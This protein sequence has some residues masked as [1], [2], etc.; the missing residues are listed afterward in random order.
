MFPPAP[1]ALV[2]KKTG[3][4]QKPKSG[5]LG[6]HDSLT[7]APENMKGQ[8]V[9]QEA[10]DFVTG[11]ASIALASSA[12][13]HPQG[14][15]QTQTAKDIPGES[16]I[17]D[18]TAIATG[19]GA[20][21]DASTSTTTGV[22]GDKTKAAV[23]NSMWEK[24]RPIM[25]IIGQICDN[26]ERFGNALSPT[27]PFNSSLYRIRLATLIIPLLLAS[28]F[29][30]PYS[31]IKVLTFSVGFGFFGDPVITPAVSRLNKIFP[32]WQKILEPRNTILKGVPTN[33]QIAITLLRIGEHSRSPLP[34]PP[35]HDKP[36]PAQ[37]AEITDEHLRA[38]GGDYPLNATKEELDEAIQHDPDVA[39]AT[40][41]ADIQDVAQSKPKK[42]ESKLL[43]FFRGTTKV[44]AE[45]AIGTDSIRAKAGSKSAKQRLG[46]VPGLKENL[47][48]GPVEF[49][50]RYEGHR[51]YAYIL[52]ENDTPY[53]A[54]SRNS[55]IGD[56]GIM[57]REDVLDSV[58]KINVTQIA[59]LKKIGGY[60]WKSK[61]VVG[62]AMQ[63]EV[64]DALEIVCRDRSST[65]I[66]AIPLRDELF[67][68]VCAMG[69]QK[70][71]SL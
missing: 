41:G 37:P 12:G 51:G 15:S 3:G 29:V 50:C 7:G 49:K 55:E 39:H 14:N 45:T 46:V 30:T 16:S 4:V 63:R 1:L 26:W 68:R 9:E 67:N 10:N 13:K 11:I 64:S 2:N 56:K 70:W 65:L 17:P 52:F 48:S 8:A 20:A 66:T 42:K 40:S 61:L 19:A 18:P 59:E 62:W 31:L 38:T 58:W 32:H 53:L 22:D 44:G 21:R 69:G 33:A 57:G 36:P 47:S 34:P 35:R 27:A 71:E 28:I 23:Q 54:F 60:G 6:S 43:S 5:V 24:M 25:H